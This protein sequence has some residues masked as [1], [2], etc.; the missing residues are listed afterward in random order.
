MNSNN[1]IAALSG[2]HD[3]ANAMVS[4][5]ERSGK[6]DVA[7]DV[8]SDYLGEKR[9][10]FR[11]YGR[12]Q[13]TYAGILAFV[14]KHANP[15]IPIALHPGDTVVYNSDGKV[16]AEGLA[17]LYAR[18]QKR[19]AQIDVYKTRARVKDLEIEIAELEELLALIEDEPSACD[20]TLVSYGEMDMPREKQVSIPIS[21]VWNYIAPE[22]SIL[23]VSAGD[24]VRVSVPHPSEG[25]EDYCWAKIIGFTSYTD[26][27]NLLNGLKGIAVSVGPFIHL[28][29]C[30]APAVL[31]ALARLRIDEKQ[32]HVAGLKVRLEYL[33][34][35][36]LVLRRFS[37]S[38][39]MSNDETKRMYKL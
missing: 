33:R 38:F 17:A 28:A 20:L 2:I 7:L 15:G 12:G 6:G 13:M 4:L 24:G 8:Y 25:V 39:W 35:V 26:A 34:E 5:Y 29:F 3:P 32:A 27:Y 36:E 31:A 23:E 10:V 21:G 14:R 22:K 18:D 19:T 1:L 16:N 37:C 9:L 11:D 30:P